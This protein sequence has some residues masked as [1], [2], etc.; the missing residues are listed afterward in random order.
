MTTPIKDYKDYN[1]NNLQDEALNR[2]V[3]YTFWTDGVSL[4][5]PANKSVEGDKGCSYLL[6]F[7]FTVGEYYELCDTIAQEHPETVKDVIKHYGK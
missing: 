5:L 1:E 2:G 4:L 6:Q 3:A 7:P